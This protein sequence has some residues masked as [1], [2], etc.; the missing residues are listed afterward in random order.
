MVSGIKTHRQTD[1]NTDR[2][3]LDCSITNQILAT[4]AFQD[5]FSWQTRNWLGHIECPN[6]LVSLSSSLKCLSL[7]VTRPPLLKGV[8]TMVL[9]SIVP[10]IVDINNHYI[11]QYVE[12]F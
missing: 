11:Q 8:C 4:E 9:C 3:I 12:G 10:Q 2:A 1:R 7:D 6:L 5:K